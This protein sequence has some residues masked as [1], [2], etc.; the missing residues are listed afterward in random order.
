MSLLGAL[1]GLVGFAMGG[2]AGAAL[3]S[4]IGSLASGGDI[5]DALKA[6]MLGFVGGGAAAGMGAAGGQ[7]IASLL[8][9]MGLGGTAAT[10][11]NP[12]ARIGSALTGGNAAAGGAATNQM[13][14]MARTGGGGLT[15]LFNLG[16]Q[17]GSILSNPLVQSLALQALQ[18]KE[19]KLTTPLQDRQLATGERRPDYRGTQ[20]ND[21]RSRRYLANGGYIEGPG[22]G[23][24]DSIPAQIYQNGMPVQE[25]ALSDGEFVLRE[26]DVNAIGGGNPGVGAAKLYAMQRQFD[27]GG[28]A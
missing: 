16:P 17:G 20:A 9:S 27:Q 11:A 19:I 23:T 25:A 8:G 3:G 15:S 1:G 13:S 22:T 24:S 28:M 6:G 18:P 26:K 10:T 4:G 14:N 21:V 5:G 2:P 12:L 7:G